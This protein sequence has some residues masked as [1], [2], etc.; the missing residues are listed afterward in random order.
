MPLQMHKITSFSMLHPDKRLLYHVFLL[1]QNS[2]GRFP[3]LNSSVDKNWSLT[4][5][6]EAFFKTRNSCCCSKTAHQFREQHRPASRS[7]C[8]FAPTTP[9][10]KRSSVFKNILCFKEKQQ[11]GCN[12][13]NKL[14]SQHLTQR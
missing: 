14:I 2:K 8:L 5:T 4:Q 1:H 3:P 10:Q 13:P 12:L 9:L 6:K 7:M 11:V